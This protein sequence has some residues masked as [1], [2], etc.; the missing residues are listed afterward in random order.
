[1]SW[2]IRLTLIVAA[3]AALYDVSRPPARQASARLA[4]AA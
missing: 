1:L 3:G 2:V 4:V